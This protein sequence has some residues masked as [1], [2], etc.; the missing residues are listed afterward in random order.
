MSDVGVRAT[1][2]PVAGSPLP[3]TRAQYVAG[4]FINC[5][6][7]ATRDGLTTGVAVLGTLARTLNDHLLWEVTSVGP[8]VWSP[9][10]FAG[11]GSGSSLIFANIASVVAF[12]FTGLISGTLLS[13]L[14]PD[15]TYELLTAPSAAI[16]A[17]TDGASIIQPTTPNTVRVIRKGLSAFFQS[18]W[19]IDPSGGNDAADGTITGPL[20]NWA[21]LKARISPRGREF[22]PF[23]ATIV[24]IAAGTLDPISIK[25]A[26]TNQLTIQGAFTSG[27]NIT[28]S[29]VT[30]TAPGTTPG[31]GVRGQIATASGTF[32]VNQ[33]LRCVSGSNPGAVAYVQE[34]NGDAQHAFVTHWHTNTLGDRGTQVDLTAGDVV[35]VDTNGV[36]VSS[37]VL[38][39]A[40]T[41]KIRIKNLGSSPASSMFIVA[42]SNTVFGI[43]FDLCQGGFSSA[44]GS[45]PNFMRCQG[46]WFA[47][48][49]YIQYQGGNH[50]TGNYLYSHSK[51]D[52]SGGDCVSNAGFQFYDCHIQAGLDWAA[53]RS[54]YGLQFERVGAGTCIVIGESS[55]FTTTLSMPVWGVTGAA[56]GVGLDFN[57]GS[58]GAFPSLLPAIVALHQVK[59]NASFYTYDQIPIIDEEF[60]VHVIGANSGNANFYN[61]ALTTTVAATNLYS[62][63]PPKGLYTFKAYLS[64]AAAGVGVTGMFAVFCTYTDDSGVSQ[65]RRVTAYQD[66]SIASSEEAMITLRS[67]SANIQWSVE[68]EP[69]HTFTR[70]NG[71]SINL[72]YSL[73]ITC[74]REV[75]P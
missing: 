51:I 72:G 70:T 74:R 4:S 1:F 6:D 63:T 22:S 65:K 13:L 73:N 2:A 68:A 55:T 48:G 24:H 30:N 3:V 16:I 8:V 29:A 56:T 66:I 62:A 26:G 7:H 32:A 14:T 47:S 71:T 42:R 25:L 33:M 15:D 23:Q 59:V 17:A 10:S 43:T 52:F 35:V 39:Q 58:R 19:Y 40:S 49:G 9:F 11:G 54:S 46:G 53:R 5:L 50:F 60:D 41:A 69:S 67:N 27:S 38:E 36:N 34:L 45:N 57:G 61:N 12:D 18:D 28:L 64:I 75:T 44:A 21:E 37:C 31:T 20:K